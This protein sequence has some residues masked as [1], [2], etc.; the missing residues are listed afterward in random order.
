MLFTP[1]AHARR[2]LSLHGL[3]STPH[4][5]PIVHRMPASTS[6]RLL[7]LGP[8]Q[9]VA[10]SSQLWCAG[11]A[12]L[13]ALIELEKV[14]GTL[15]PG[16]RTEPLQ[17]DALSTHFERRSWCSGAPQLICTSAAAIS[18]HFGISTIRWGPPTVQIGSFAGLIS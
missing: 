12:A 8:T 10:A 5:H 6:D 18:I 15:P 11:H 2:P 4:V 9:S 7:A 14:A 13:P 16:L 17:S 1:V 3:A